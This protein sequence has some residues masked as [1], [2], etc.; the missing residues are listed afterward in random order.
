[1]NF[2]N[3]MRTAWYSI[4]AYKLRIFLTMIGIIIGISSVSAI[5][6]IGEGLKAEASTSM[7][8]ANLNKITIEYMP[9]GGQEDI[10]AV[11]F[12]E[13]DIIE[14][15]KIDDVKDVTKNNSE[16]NFFMGTYQDM[17]YF[18]KSVAGE[19]NN[20]SDSDG[21]M[22]LASGRNL[23]K[24]ES[25][26]DSRVIVLG[27]EMAKQ[28]FE[29]PERAIGK[30]VT[31]KGEIFEV[32]GVREEASMDMGLNFSMDFSDPN[33]S[34]IPS[35]VDFGE[36]ENDQIWNLSVALE[37]GGDKEKIL[38]EVKDKLYE[39]HP[40]IQGEY[41]EFDME[42]IIESMQSVIGNITMFVAF[43]TGI[44][45]LVGGIGVM[46]IM[47]VSVTERKREIGIRRAIGAKPRDI[48]I[49]FLIEAVFI[50]GLGGV[51]GIAFGYLFSMAVGAFLPF[52]PVMTVRNF[53]GAASISMITGLVFGII[54]AS[55][56]A[57]L[58]PIVAIYK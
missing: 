31:V 37:P 36:Q 58:D 21:K 41:V 48:L 56:A 14:L 27:H 17:S 7:E 44:S 11:P 30:G 38:T 32:V 39:L 4:R 26:G 3:F 57:K 24:V 45:L 40:E 35:K 28:L 50:T 1:M 29:S 8:S 51:I 18:D 42:E 2:Y 9:P 49:Q 34:T 5:L 12:E 52:P 43:V 46:N 19:V 13:D 22:A 53:I 6:A 47:Y 20:Y 55:K 33:S 23:S 54:P 15:K 10:N 16:N 25:E